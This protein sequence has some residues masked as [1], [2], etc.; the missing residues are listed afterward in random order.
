MRS[1]AMVLTV[2]LCTLVVVLGSAR[3][4]ADTPLPPPPV[5]SEWAVV[6]AI[7]DPQD[8]PTSCSFQYESDAQ[9]VE[10]GGG[11][12]APAEVPCDP[13]P[14]ESGRQ[15]VSAR[16]TG[17]TPS[18]TYHY[19]VAVSGQGGTTTSSDTLFTTLPPE[20]DLTTDPATDVT[21]T[22]VTLHGTVN[23]HGL[24]TTC[25]FE[26]GPSPAYGDEEPCDPEPGNGDQSVQVS[27]AIDATPGTVLHYHLVATNA[28]GSY[29]GPDETVVIPAAIPPTIANTMVQT[30]AR[31][32]ATGA[33]TVNPN[34]SPTQCW[35]ESG[36]QRIPCNPEPG[37]G[38]SPVAVTA[39][40]PVFGA[41]IS[42]R[43]VA[44]NA[45]GT[46]YGPQVG[47]GVFWVPPPRPGTLR[48][49]SL[50]RPRHGEVTLTLTCDGAWRDFCR[51]TLKLTARVRLHG[52]RQVV[53]LGSAP[54]SFTGPGGRVLL[55]VRL[56]ARA[57]RLF[58]LH[59]RLR[60]S[61]HAVA[62]TAAGP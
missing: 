21:A 52:R 9:F 32:T 47:M 23:P 30:I 56:S 7:I 36:S 34:G 39:P 2:V 46:T 57:R 60:I 55:A 54:Y 20:P 58:R 15:T 16:I 37:D 28:N 24:P 12:A 6:T 11:F 18:T 31:P 53:V 38:T 33:A 43:V 29:S 1:K 59:P 3:S 41:I 45:G 19:H 51:G 50:G 48:V 42:F 14:T 22:S 40:I 35:F 17:L 8:P 25:V 44:S 4:G 10:D 5:G 61:A 26:F 62:R 49:L 27:A 13:Q